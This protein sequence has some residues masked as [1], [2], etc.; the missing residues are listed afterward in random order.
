MRVLSFSLLIWRANGSWCGVLV[1][2]FF[3]FA[4]SSFTAKQI[5]LP[6]LLLKDLA[7]WKWDR[8]R[9]G[10]DY[11]LF[12]YRMRRVRSGGCET[13]FLFLFRSTTGGAKFPH[14]FLPSDPVS[15]RWWRCFII[16]EQCFQFLLLAYLVFPSGPCYL[17]SNYGWQDLNSCTFSYIW[18][19]PHHPMPGVATCIRVCGR[20]GLFYYG[21]EAQNRA[22]GL[23]LVGLSKSI[24]TS[25]CN[26]LRKLCYN[27]YFRP[28]PD[29]STISNL[30]YE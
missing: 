9:K 6:V 24:A 12:Q 17:C 8:D 27:T 29:Y 30:K 18:S 22:I 7:S 14:I 23:R 4:R 25:F 3:S 2:Y 11:C 13:I 19:G 26:R 10:K 20:Q 21:Y 28:P 5:W 16:W 1:L 15:I